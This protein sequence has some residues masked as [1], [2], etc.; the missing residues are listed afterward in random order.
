MQEDDVVQ[1]VVDSKNGRTF[2]N[3]YASPS[4]TLFKHIGVAN[5]VPSAGPDFILTLCA[6]HVVR[7]P[8]A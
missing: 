2:Y 7:Q 8:A 3:W 4:H 5:I 1:Q 6:R